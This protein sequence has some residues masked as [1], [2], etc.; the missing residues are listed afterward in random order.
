[1]Q[2]YHATSALSL[3]AWP[4]ARAGRHAGHRPQRIAARATL[5]LAFKRCRFAPEALIGRTG[6]R[7]TAGA[8]GFLN[9]SQS[10]D[11]PER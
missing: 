7:F 5:R 1:M 2:R 3:T 8:S 6:T 9:F 10:F 4:P 11:R